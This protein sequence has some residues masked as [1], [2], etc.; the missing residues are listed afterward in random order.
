MTCDDLD[1]YVW[2]GGGGDSKGVLPGWSVGWGCWLFNSGR[3]QESAGL[4]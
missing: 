1:V 2:G 4:R 3:L